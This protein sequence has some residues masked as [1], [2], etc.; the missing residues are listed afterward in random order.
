[1][2]MKARSRETPRSQALALCVRPLRLA[3]SQLSLWMVLLLV[4]LCVAIAPA[5]RAQVAANSNPTYQ[6]L[7]NLTLSGES[8]SVTGLDL[9]RDAGTFH[10]RTGVVCFTAPVAGKVTGAVFSGD[11]SFV[12]DA[13]ASER[14]ML[15]LLTKQD[16]FAE[17]FSQMVLR[18]TD[19]TYDEIKSK[20]SAASGGCD[21]GDLKESQRVFRN[22]FEDN[23][24]VRILDDVWRPQPGRP[25]LG[26]HSRQA[27]QR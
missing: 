7:R 24:E 6:A 5:A 1:M 27:L 4:L 3:S 8:V 18:F 21:A 17:N 23:L 10:L 20:G 2:T 19:S 12:L 26:L 14:G 22:A 25:V 13:P 11:G 15:K 9:K 16:E